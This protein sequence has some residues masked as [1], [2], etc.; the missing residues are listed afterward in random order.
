MGRVLAYLFPCHTHN[1]DDFLSHVGLYI[2]IETLAPSVKNIRVWRMVWTCF[3]KEMLF[4]Q[5]RPTAIMTSDLAYVQVI[6]VLPRERTSQTW[7]KI[8]LWLH[9]ISKPDQLYR[10]RELPSPKESYNSRRAW[11]YLRQ[12]YIFHNT[13]QATS[14]F[15]CPAKSHALNSYVRNVWRG[16]GCTEYALSPF[17]ELSHNK[18]C[19]TTS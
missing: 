4:N 5:D 3:W 18:L 13:P 11:Q 17:R 16:I 7:C 6:Y 14:W 19:R 9:L 10:Y 1:G 8:K 12:R 2:Q 15:P